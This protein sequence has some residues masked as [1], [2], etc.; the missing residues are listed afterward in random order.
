MTKKK[1]EET[2]GHVAVAT[3][4]FA[5]SESMLIDPN[6]I[7][8][9]TAQS[10]GTGVLPT[11]LDLG[12]GIFQTME[13]HDDKKPLW[14]MLLSPEKEDREKA[15]ELIEEHEPDL[16]SLEKSIGIVQLQAIGVYQREPDE[17]DVI[18]GMR[19]ALAHALRCART[20][21]VVE[22]EAK[23]FDFETEPT[24]AQL[25]LLALRENK[26]RKAEN[27]IDLAITF[28]ALVDSGMTPDQV[29]E[30]LGENGEDQRSG[31]YV[32]NYIKLLHKKLDDKR[33][34]I[35]TGRLKIDPALTL[36]ASRLDKT[37]NSA[38]GRG[39]G[40]GAP[41]H[42]LQGT[43][44]LIKL[45][46][47]PKKPSSIDD[48]EWELFIAPDVRKWLAHKLGLRYSE[49]KPAPEKVKE[50]KKDKAKSKG[51]KVVEIKFERAVEL[52]ICLGKTNARTMSLEDLSKTLSNIHS[53]AEEDMNVGE[54]S[55]SLQKLLVKLHNWYKDGV[56][57][58]VVK[59]PKVKVKK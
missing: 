54:E 24:E 12:Y 2:N 21:K 34:Q 15:I 46:D 50:E 51:G 27:P 47:A 19:R 30:S 4:K 59:E 8:A 23:A 1:K 20:G 26:D 49:W 13:D 39:A 55:S 40:K 11:L 32:R 36:L 25:K 31:Q 9:N 28:K 5:G 29:G 35:Q 42:R 43:N 7:V 52:L 10:R 3:P 37:K 38:E 17:F 45:Y 44:T 14:D 53:V 58:K 18:Y 33:M 56:K 48:V 16:V 41:R 57:I 6:S 22:I